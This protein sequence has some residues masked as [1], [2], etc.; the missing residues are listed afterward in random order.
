VFRLEFGRQEPLPLALSRVCIS[1]ID[2][3]IAAIR[4]LP[5]PTA[6]IHEA[7]KA[8]KRAR[9]MLRLARDEIGHDIYRA[10]NIVLRDLGRL[11]SPVRTAQ[12]MCDLARTITKELGGAIATQ[13]AD[14]LIETLQRRSD[15]W[16]ALVLEDRQL[17]TDVLTTLLAARAR[18][19]TWPVADTGDA[20]ADQPRHRIPDD[21]ATIEPGIRRVY[22]RGREAMAI[23]AST[24]S[25][26]AFHAWRK[27]VKYLRHHMEALHLMQPEV[28]GA[29]AGEL[30]TLGETLGEEHDLAELEQL[31]AADPSLMPDRDGRRSLLVDITRRRLELQAVAIAIGETVYRD[32][33]RQFTER[34]GSFWSATHG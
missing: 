22:R 10:E 8:L 16:A 32:P 33:P 3:A 26:L 28:I 23:A 11:L 25:G 12:V 15:D 7:R 4:D 20:A 19:Q 31:I 34:I 13:A 21:F 2:E 24:Q 29:I 9:A 1:E 18:Y 6:G 17:V 27:R 5:E 14:H 30:N